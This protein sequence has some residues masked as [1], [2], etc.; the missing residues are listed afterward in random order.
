[1]LCCYTALHR[2]LCWPQEA[3]YM[4]GPTVKG[5]FALHHCRNQEEPASVLLS[6]PWGFLQPSRRPRPLGRG[7]DAFTWP[8]E[9]SGGF[10]VKSLVPWKAW[11][12]TNRFLTSHV[13]FVTRVAPKTDFSQACLEGWQPH[14]CRGLEPC[15]RVWV[16][17]HSP[18]CPKLHTRRFGRGTETFVPSRVI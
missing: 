11:C 10:L 16:Y 12:K 18:E 4:P 3:T 2:L 17:V 9:Q 13:W 15:P 6:F 5:L 8:V 14:I 7:L 1:M